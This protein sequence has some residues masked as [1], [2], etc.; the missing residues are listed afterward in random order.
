[1]LGACMEPLLYVVKQRHLDNDDDSGESGEERQDS[2]YI[3]WGLP[4]GK[5]CLILLNVSLSF[6]F[7]VS[8]SINGGMGYCASLSM[9]IQL[10]GSGNNWGFKD[11]MER[12]A[13]C[14]RS[15]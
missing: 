4:V 13:T 12:S 8:C 11:V 7:N 1:M 9:L 2:P 6:A 15:W 3:A 14:Q 5:E 10:P